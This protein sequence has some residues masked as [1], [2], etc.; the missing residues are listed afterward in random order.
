MLPF[1]ACDIFPPLDVDL[2]DDIAP[3]RFLPPPPPPPPPSPP[4]NADCLLPPLGVI[5]SK[6]EEACLGVDGTDAAAPL[7][8]AGIAVAE[9]PLGSLVK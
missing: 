7:G 6:L 9:P 5:G 3:R 8:V 2:L 4:P 1:C